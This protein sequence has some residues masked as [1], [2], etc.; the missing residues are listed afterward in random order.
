MKR[1]FLLLV[2]TL[3]SFSSLIRAQEYHAETI[4]DSTHIL[5]GD[6]LNINL[7]VKAP[8]GK[9][10]IIP[11]INQ[12]ILG[13]NGIEWIQNSLLDTLSEGNTSTYRQ[14][15]TV[16]SFEEGQ[17][18]FPAIPV[19]DTDSSLL[20]QTESFSFNVTTIAVDTTAAYKDIKLPVRVP[21][22]FKELVPYMLITLGSLIILGLIVFFILK[23]RNKKQ[24]QTRTSRP[25]PAVRSDI[26]ALE[27][28]EALRKK[29]LWQAGKV[30]Q[31]YSELTEIVRIFIDQRFEINAMEMVSEEIMAALAMKDTDTEAY[32][33][34]K[35][36]L[37]VADLVKFAKWDPLPDDHD[38]CF[39][40]AR[41]FVELN[42]PEPQ[43]LSRTE[44]KKDK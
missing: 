28:L 44:L 2:F 17:Y 23:Y 36:L 24:T 8:A 31:Y 10:V 1:K 39:K 4:V 37:T 18:I 29:K 15:I 6:H 14:T 35:D 13:D 12:E 42:A 16:T 30:K 9:P 7:T 22:T 11:Q 25:K 20:A 27:A 32:N 38:R 26:A 43:D 5:I 19:V 41:E 3:C 34:L 33:K 40:D 21:L